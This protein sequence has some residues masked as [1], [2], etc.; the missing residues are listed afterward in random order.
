LPEEFDLGDP[1]A[2]GAAQASESM[3]AGPAAA[4][5]GIP[6]VDALF[7]FGLEFDFDEVEPDIAVD[8]ME[9]LGD[10]RDMPG[11]FVEHGQ[12]EPEA[13]VDEQVGDEDLAQIDEVPIV[14]HP[15]DG[16]EVHAPPPPP[17]EVLAD[18]AMVDGDGKV[19][20]PVPPYQEYH[21][22]GRITAW[23]KNVPPASRNAARRCC[24]HTGCSISK[25]RRK[26]TDRQLLLWL[27][28]G[29]LLEHGSLPPDAAARDEHKRLGL[30]MLP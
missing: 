28:A 30:T 8:L 22:V 16:I 6:E 18:A 27:F 24:L 25:K 13:D 1:T 20:C 15:D 4:F 26:V 17:E 7:N 19:W 3:A 11:P 10:G 14:E 29:K 12:A 5:A 2:F 9:V 21:P 23:P